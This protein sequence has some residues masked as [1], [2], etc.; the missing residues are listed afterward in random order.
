[1][2]ASCG[3]SDVTWVLMK[4]SAIALG[5]EAEAD[6]ISPEG[7]FAKVASKCTIWVV[8]DYDWE[9]SQSFYSLCLLSL[10]FLIE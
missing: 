1:M 9:W 4:A 3:W 10:E 2:D 5:V 8:I 7:A 6:L